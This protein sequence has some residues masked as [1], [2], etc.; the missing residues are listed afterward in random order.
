MLQQRRMKGVWARW[1]MPL[2]L[3]VGKYG[4]IFALYMTEKEKPYTTQTAITC[5]NRSVLKG[6]RSKH[7]S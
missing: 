2:R 6:I 5:I 3:K 7:I 1:L 4:H